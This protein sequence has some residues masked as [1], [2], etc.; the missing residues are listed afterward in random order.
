MTLEQL[1]Q[2]LAALRQEMEQAQ[3]LRTQKADLE[4]QLRECRDRRQ[5]AAQVLAKEQE[6]VD[7]LEGM[8]LAYVFHTVLGNRV[9]KLDQERREAL[10]AHLSHE[11]A[12][13]DEADLETR[14]EQVRG[15][16]AQLS[17]AEARY[18]AKLEEKRDC[19]KALHGSE[20]EQ[21]A[22]LEE[23]IAGAEN[24][25][26]EIRE[27]ERAGR[28]VLASLDRAADSLASA[29]DWGIW[30]MMGGGLITTVI[31]HDHID[32]ARD[33]VADAQAQ[34]SRF[35][36]ELADVEIDG[37]P[38]VSIGEFATFADYFFDGLIADWFVQ[39]KIHDSQESVIQARTQV[40]RILLQLEGTAGVQEDRAR[41][42]RR[43][44]DR[45][46]LEL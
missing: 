28:A 35:R 11:Q 45:L 32:E 6:D 46:T 36:T 29:E 1:N 37:T 33:W 9:E 4:Q 13:R 44:L 30:D 17:N 27:A 5:A 23:T 18:Q 38:T 41:Q 7:R 19:L 26:R 21:I 12:L 3:K 39:D 42:A 8:S 10:A 31:K 20:A 43:G 2:E 24:Q 15:R 40:N 22:A 25:L 34:L 14:L 16:W